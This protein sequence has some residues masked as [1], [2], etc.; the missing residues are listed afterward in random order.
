M[1][2]LCS[3]SVR[4][5]S[6]A[7]AMPLLG[8]L[9]VVGSARVNSSEQSGVA[10]ETP[11]RQDPAAAAAVHAGVAGPSAAAASR[12]APLTAAGSSSKMK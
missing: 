10:A 5:S 2:P 11:R 8:P 4:R 7:W 6:S 9:T 1:M 3:L 12:I